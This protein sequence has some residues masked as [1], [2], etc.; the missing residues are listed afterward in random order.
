MVGWG[1]FSSGYSPYPAPGRLLKGLLRPS[2]SCH[3]PA[4]S[5]ILGSPATGLL[6]AT[7]LKLLE[8]VASGYRQRG[9]K[10]TGLTGPV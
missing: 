4:S 2:C 5:L 3:L 6:W 8:G 1:H 10:A 9:T 7:S